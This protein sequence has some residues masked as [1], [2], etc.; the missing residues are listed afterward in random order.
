MVHA[1]PS[2]IVLVPSLLPNIIPFLLASHFPLLTRA[3]GQRRA[4]LLS[5]PL[6]L[7]SSSAEA[8]CEF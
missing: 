3:F 5:L 2:I 8:I 1:L 6:I 4:E 7:M